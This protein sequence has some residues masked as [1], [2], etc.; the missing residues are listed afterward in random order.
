MQV[1]RQRHA[2]GLKAL[3]LSSMGQV[4]E[5]EAVLRLIKRSC[6]GPVEGEVP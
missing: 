2:L 4:E 3:A 1:V 5:A 6:K